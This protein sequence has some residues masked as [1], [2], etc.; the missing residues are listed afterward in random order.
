MAKTK[1]SKRDETLISKLDFDRDE[2]EKVSVQNPFSGDSCL[3][4]TRGVALYEYVKGSE[5]LSQWDNLQKGLTLF[6]KLYP[7]EYYTLLD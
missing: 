6:R 5:A 1:L 7:S 3:L 2:T 4:D